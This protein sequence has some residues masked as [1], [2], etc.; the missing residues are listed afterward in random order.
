[1]V[2]PGGDAIDTTSGMI[3]RQQPAAIYCVAGPGPHAAVRR[4]A[5]GEVFSRFGREPPR[6]LRGRKVDIPTGG[7]WP[8]RVECRGQVA[9][10]ERQQGC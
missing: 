8:P 6:P 4:H 9:G 3:L 5:I 1:M 7:G 10:I 2:S